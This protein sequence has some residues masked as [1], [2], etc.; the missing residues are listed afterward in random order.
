MGRI[1]FGAKAKAAREKRKVREQAVDEPASDNEAYDNLRRP[2]G[3]RPRRDHWKAVNAKTGKDF[4]DHCRWTPPTAS[5]LHAHHII[6]IACGGPDT[7]VNLIVLCPNCHAIAHY[8]TAR[9]SLTRTYTGPR[10]ADQLRE[11]MW[12][13]KTPARLRALQ[14][15]HLLR[16]VA[17]I[18]ASMRA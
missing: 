1:Y 11:W 5:I 14:K 8:V 18:L 2:A 15:A 3:Q 9:S 10:T 12:A 16:N 13:V 6:P 7:I 4:C 17:P